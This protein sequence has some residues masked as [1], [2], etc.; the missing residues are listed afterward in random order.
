M[1]K[2]GAVVPA[3]E[4]DRMLD[5]FSRAFGP[6]RP[7]VK[8]PSSPAL[9]GAPA[10]FTRACLTCHDRDLIAQQRLT[11]AGWV[12]E[13]EKMI[14]WGAPVSESDKS[15]LVDYLA[16]PLPRGEEGQGDGALKGAG[17]AR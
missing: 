3:A 9:E 5:A 1:I 4:R 16:S 14:R 6:A 7:V 10:V 13:V 8:E 12:R 2:W 11:R 17:A 15:A